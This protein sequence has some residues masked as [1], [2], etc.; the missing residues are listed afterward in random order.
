[1][2]VELT[3]SIHAIMPIAQISDKFKKR[4]FVLLINDSEYPQHRKLECQQDKVSMLDN[5][6]LND[7]VVVSFNI[8]GREHRKN[9]GEISYFNSDVVWK[10]EKVISAQKPNTD[11]QTPPH[12][13][14]SELFSDTV[15]DLPF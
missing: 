8:N 13:P 15:N 10:M 5:Y 2:T 3:G 4:E 7:E 9:T 6:N 1:M 14:V 12:Q 11:I